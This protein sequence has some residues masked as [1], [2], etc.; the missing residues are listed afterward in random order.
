MT[1]PKDIDEYISG[2]P[3]EIQRFL[4]QVRATIKKAAPKA[5]EVISYGMPA[6]KM[7]GLLVWFAAHSKHIGFYPKASGIEAFK[8][9]LSIYKWAKGSVQFPFNK[10]MPLGLITRIVEFRVNENL[11]R[12]K[13]KK[14]Q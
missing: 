11:H 1:T 13:P 2:Y 8:K 10:P 4:Q 3:M 5:V 7:D 14:K 9:E 6:F 12:I